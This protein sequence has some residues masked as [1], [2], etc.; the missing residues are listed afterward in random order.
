M[1]NQP[2]F[3]ENNGSPISWRETVCQVVKSG[4]GSNTGSELGGKVIISETLKD[5]DVLS[6]VAVLNQAEA[7]APGRWLSGEEIS[8]KSGV[9]LMKMYAVLGRLKVDKFVSTQTNR[10]GKRWWRVNLD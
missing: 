9:K 3:I 1:E 2:P 7:V 10:L 4:T 5:S 8:E 6:I